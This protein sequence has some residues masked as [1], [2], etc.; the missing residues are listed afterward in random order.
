LVSD[1][2]IFLGISAEMFLQISTHETDETR[3]TKKLVKMRN[4]TTK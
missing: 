1:R 2:K 3:P 4:Y